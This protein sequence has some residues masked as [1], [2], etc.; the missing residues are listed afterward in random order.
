M[1]IDQKPGTPS[2]IEETKTYEHKILIAKIVSMA[3]I[4]LSFC[5]SGLLV[6]LKLAQCKNYSDLSQAQKLRCDN[7]ANLG[8]VLSGSG[9]ITTI[10]A[11]V[12]GSSWEESLRRAINFERRSKGF[13]QTY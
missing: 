8:M 5:G 11:N 6:Y 12:L 10:G 9:M 2:I 4:C 1:R 3:S 13:P 7:T